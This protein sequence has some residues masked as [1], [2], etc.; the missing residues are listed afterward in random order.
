M[1]SAD[2]TTFDGEF[3]HFTDAPCDPKPVQSPLPILVGTRSPRMLGITARQADEWNTWGT[4]EQAAAHRTALLA[5]CDKAGRDPA[6]M[7]TSVNA[8]IDLGGGDPPAGRPTLSGSVSAVVDQLGQY[9]EL[10]FD[11]FILPDWNL[12]A[13][14]LTDTLATIKTEVLD[15]LAA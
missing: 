13:V 2:S 15:Q 11:E 12:A 5:A 7:R 4:P 14:K 1:L 10:G 8:F 6:T 9:A 3:Y